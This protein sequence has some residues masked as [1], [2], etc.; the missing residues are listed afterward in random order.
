MQFSFACYHQSNSLFLKKSKT[1]HPQ[2]DFKTQVKFADMENGEI[3][4]H[5]QVKS[6]EELSF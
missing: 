3:T 4:F 2:N 6:A 1:Q 5:F